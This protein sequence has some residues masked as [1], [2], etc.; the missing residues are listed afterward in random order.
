MSSANP[1]IRLRFCIDPDRIHRQMYAQSSPAGK[2][3]VS[4]MCVPHSEAGYGRGPLAEGFPGF[5]FD[6]PFFF[7]GFF[8]FFFGV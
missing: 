4:R 7:F 1:H 3:V 6:F 5:F 8:S 2:P